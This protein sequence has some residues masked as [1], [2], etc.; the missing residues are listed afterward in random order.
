MRLTSVLDD[1]G[2]SELVTPS[3]QLSHSR[4]YCVS[5][6][7]QSSLTILIQPASQARLDPDF[8]ETL[9][10][11]NSNYSTA[12]ALPTVAYDLCPLLHIDVADVL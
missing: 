7:P 10:L 8:K 11:G 9:Q 3:V 4:E 2:Y 12:A 1:L 5:S 6:H